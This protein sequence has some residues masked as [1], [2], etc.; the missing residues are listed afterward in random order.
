VRHGI[1]I[2]PELRWAEAVDRWRRAERLG[3]DHAWALDHLRYRHLPGKAWYASLPTL[4]AA[5]A[6]TSRIRLGTLVA[7]PNFRHPVTF[8]KEILTLDD[9]SGGRM[10]CGVGA[11]GEGADSEV[12]GVAP[13][14]R[15]QRAAR[16][17]EFVELT[18][19]LLRQAETS[20]DGEFFQAR[21]AHM[22]P[23]CVQH[24]R[25]P[26]AIAA[27]GP[28]GLRLAARRG[29]AWVTVGRPGHFEPGRFDQ[30]AGV[31]KD[32]VARLTDACAEEGRDPASIDRI[33]VA[34]VQL[35]GVL[36]SAASFEEADGLFGELGF[37]DMIVF[38][39]RS[40]A[41]FKTRESV[42]DDIA[43]LLERGQHAPAG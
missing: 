37:T 18:D 31:L 30:M 5:A 1:A 8:A 3:F 23:G 27:A 41:P 24:P 9:I 19:L 33:I 34:G 22:H 14:S 2:L 42:L 16:F 39:P 15:A 40:T 26:L 13:P 32:Q 4:A 36:Q 25:V 21:E 28:R 6:V 38:W 29:D 11:G 17:A 7:S 20:Y 35:N 10:I 12:L 43:P